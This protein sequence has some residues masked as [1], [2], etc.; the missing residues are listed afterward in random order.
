[1]TVEWPVLHL[2]SRSAVVCY[3]EVGVPAMAVDATRRPVE[4][5][6]STSSEC[7]SMVVIAVMAGRWNLDGE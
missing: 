5:A 2:P 4:G 7:V 3:D 1:M 6:L